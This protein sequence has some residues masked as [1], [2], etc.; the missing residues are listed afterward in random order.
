LK[1]KNKTRNNTIIIIVIIVSFALY[2]AGVLSGLYTSKLVQKET[3]KEILFLQEYV[4]MFEKNLEDSQ[5]E[6]IY[7][8]TLEGEDKCEFYKISINRLLVNTGKLSEALPYRLEEYE[9]NNNL[10]QDYLDLKKEYTQLSIKTWIYVNDFYNNCENEMIQG[11]YFYSSDCEGCIRQ[12]EELD[13]LK[14]SKYDILIFTINIESNNSIVRHIKEKYEL[15]SVPSMYI[16]GQ[17]FK[18]KIY[19]SEEIIEMIEK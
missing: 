17:I 1:R 19:S 18:E 12:G 14:N 2:M 11:L 13:K 16:N 8:K 7:I 3:A 5:L 6:E 9:K 4:E 15:N 10:T